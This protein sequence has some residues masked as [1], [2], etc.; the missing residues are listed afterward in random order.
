MGP[1]PF[2]AEDGCCALEREGAGGGC[3]GSG[4]IPVSKWEHMG[5]CLETAVEVSGKARFPL[6]AGGGGGENKCIFHS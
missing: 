2:F 5:P 6:E 1:H 3:S 4:S